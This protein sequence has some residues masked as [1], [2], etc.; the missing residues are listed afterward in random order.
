MSERRLVKRDHVRELLHVA[1]LN[2][3]TCKLIAVTVDQLEILRVCV[4]YASRQIN[5]NDEDVGTSMYY[6]PSNVDFDD[7]LAL[8]HDL[9]LRLMETCDVGALVDALLALQCVCTNLENLIAQQSLDVGVQ[10]ALPVIDDQA[11]SAEDR[12]L[13][14]NTGLPSTAEELCELANTV[15]GWGT[16]VIT[17]KVLPL[18]EDLA[19]KLALL[20][21]ATEAFI[22][23]TGGIGLLPGVA[24]AAF[25]AF[26]RWLAEGAVINVQNWIAGSGQEAVCSLYTGFVEGSWEGARS[27][28]AAMIDAEVQL[29]FGDKVML[30]WFLTERYVLQAIQYSIDALLLDPD[31]YFTYQCTSCEPTAGCITFD[32]ASWTLTG[33]ADLQPDGSII[34]SGTTGQVAAYRLFDPELE[35]T[36]WFDYDPADLAPPA[37]NAFSWR[38]QLDAT[39]VD[40]GDISTS[41][42]GR[43]WSLAITD[44]PADT[45]EIR[46][47]SGTT[48]RIYTVCLTP[49]S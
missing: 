40:S 8:V 49:A 29:S 25:T 3:S 36:M 22:I 19:N 13:I 11:P 18:G 48:V 14:D 9:E 2:D 41:D 37:F 23:L 24:I 10:G 27:N 34:V 44:V 43:H 38:T 33:I 45:L 28:L 20:I 7:I 30:K 42:N 31:D 5:W 4:R 1:D 39:P 16:E 12:A 17:E 15:W 26:V 21:V 46:A 32:D 35:G 6:L 47:V